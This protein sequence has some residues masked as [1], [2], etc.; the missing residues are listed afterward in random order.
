MAVLVV[1]AGSAGAWA[2][3]LQSSGNFHVVEP[4]LAY[5]SNTL[6]TAQLKDVISAN[7][8]KTIINL[9]GGST[10][11]QWY[12]DEALV[13]DAMGVTMIDIP[14]SDSRVPETAT[15]KTLV[16]ALE[17]APRP[18][19]IHCKAGADRTGLAAALFEYLVAGR[20]AEEAAAQLSLLYGHFPWYPSQT[21]AM[22][23]TFWD[24]ANDRPSFALNVMD[25]GVLE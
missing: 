15:L 2:G 20:S 16:D 6:G 7:Q 18:I 22:D 25:G 5:R 13:S 12:R 9:R 19:L 21:G 14:M 3:Y 4:G 11:E 10:A 8:I 24:V 1:L 23:K 17:G